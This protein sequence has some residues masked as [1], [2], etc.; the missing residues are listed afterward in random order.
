MKGC[1]LPLSSSSRYNIIKDF[2]SFKFFDKQMLALVVIL[3][4]LSESEIILIWGGYYRN[5]FR[6]RH[7]DLLH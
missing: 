3:I 4:F 5:Q 7:T 2:V 6:D 1:F